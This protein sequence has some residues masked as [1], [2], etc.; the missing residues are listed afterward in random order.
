[1]QWNEEKSFN[2]L[3]NRQRMILIEFKMILNSLGYSQYLLLFERKTNNLH[4]DWKSSRV[5]Y[6]L[7][8]Y[9]SDIIIPG[10]FISLLILPDCGDR[11]SGYWHAKDIPNENVSC[12]EISLIRGSM[13]RCFN[14]EGR[15]HQQIKAQFLPV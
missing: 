12:K 9:F 1:M 14:T 5:N 10:A 13:V 6:T 8:C 7:L 15:T 4:S 2:L 11:S 3:D